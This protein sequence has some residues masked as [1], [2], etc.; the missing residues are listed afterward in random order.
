[1]KLKSVTEKYGDY[2]DQNLKRKKRKLKLKKI[3]MQRDFFSINKLIIRL[4]LH[5][6]CFAF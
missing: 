3:D 1:M 6:F 4:I 2:T 5:K